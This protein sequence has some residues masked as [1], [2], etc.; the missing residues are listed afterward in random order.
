MRISTFLIIVCTVLFFGAAFKANAQAPDFT[1]TNLRHTCGPGTPATGGFVVHVTNADASQDSLTVFV[2][3]GASVV[4]Q[5]TIKPI[6]S[7]PFD[8]T[9][10]GLTGA[11]AG[12]GRSYLVLVADEN[13]SSVATNGPNFTIFNFQA[14]V[15]TVTNN[16]NADCTSPSGAIT[17]NLAGNTSAAAQPIV[18][19]WAGPVG[20]VDPGTK[21][22][23]GLRGGDYTLTYKDSNTPATSC[24]LGP[25]HI[26]DPSSVDFTITGP[27][28][29]CVGDSESVTV[30]ATTSGYTYDVMEGATVLGSGAGTGSAIFITVPSA[31]LPAG[32]HT[33]TVRATQGACNPKFNNAPNLTVTVN[34]APTYSNG[35]P[36]NVCSS[37]ASGVNL[38]SFKTGALDATSFNITNIATTLTATAGS[39]ATGTGFAANVIADDVWKNTTNAPVN[40]VYTIVPLAGICPG[41]SFTVT[42]AINPQ[43][44]FNSITTPAVCSSSAIGVT[45]DPQKKATSVNATS[46]NVL[47]INPHGMT[48]VGGSPGT[49]GATNTTLADDKWLNVTN[50]IVNVDYTITP[51]SASGCVGDQFII[52]VPISPQPDYNNFNNAPATVCSQDAINVDL[53]T[54]QKGTSIAATSFN[55]TG[56]TSTGLTIAGGAPATG[57]GL[58]NT[59]IADDQWKNVT[60]ANVN[61]VYTV[62]PVIGTCAGSPFTITVA[63]KPE[64]DYNNGTPTVC[65][66]VS[67]GVNLDSFAKGTSVVAT[68][69]DITSIV[70][71]GL[72]AKAGNPVTGTGF[73][74]AEI[75]NDQW[76]NLTSSSKTATYTVVPNNG[77]CDGTP[78]TVT[79]TINAEPDV[80]NYDS[81]P[82]GVC[83]G[84][85]LGID[86]ST[87]AV[88][89]S[90]PATTYSITS[91]ASTSLTASGGSPA[92]GTGLSNS[93]IADDAW[94]NT[95]TGTLPVVYTI[96]P[97]AGTCAGDPFT[98]TV[99]IVPRPVFTN[100]S[101]G[102]AAGGICAT[103]LGIDLNS[104]QNPAGPAAT[105][106]NITSI[107]STSLVAAGGSPATGNG[108]LNTEIADDVW[109]NTTAVNHDVVYTIVPVNGS[110]AG[111]SFTVTVTIK[112]QPNY[113]T[114]GAGVCSNIALGPDLNSLKVSGSSTADSFN[115]TSIAV[116]PGLT[117]TSATPIVT[118]ITTSSLITDKW[119]NVTA[120]LLNVVYT[121]IP[122]TG[123]CAGAPFTLTISVSPEPVYSSVTLADLCSE[124]L[125]NFDLETQYGGTSVHATTFSYVA[126]P[127]AG[128]TAF[129]STTLTGS[130]NNMVIAGHQWKNVTNAALTVVYTITPQSGGFCNGVPFTITVKIN[131]Q[132]D[133]SDLPA[134]SLCSETAL[135]INLNTLQ[136]PT[137]ILATT[138]DIVSIT[139]TNLTRKAGTSSVANG[140]PNT[141]LAADAWTN[142]TA[143]TQDVTYVI[144]PVIGTCKGDPFTVKVTIKPQPDYFTASK[145][146]CSQV[147]T[148]VDL[149]ILANPAGIA[150]DSYSI[151]S[152]TSAGLTA[153]AGSPATGSGLTSTVISD[154]AWKNTTSGSLDVV[155][156]IV[157]FNG[158]CAGVPFTMTINVGPEPVGANDNVTSCTG[159]SVGYD[160]VSNV[161]T[162]GNNLVTGTTFSWLAVD[163]TNV[164]GESTTAQAGGTI[165]NNLV[166]NTTSSQLVVYTVVPTS[167]TGCVGASFTVTVTVSPKPVLVVGQT[168]QACSGTAVGYSILLNPANLPAGTTFTW[169]APVM[170]DG[171]TQGTAQSTELA[172]GPIGTIHINDVLVNT[173]SAPITATYTITPSINGF[174]QGTPQTVV[175]TVNQ[176]ALA[177]AGINQAIC[178]DNGPYTLVGSSV[179]GSAS[180]GTWSIVSQPAGGDGALS[181]T[182]P[183]ANPNIAMVTFTATV[184]GDYTLALTTDDPAGICGPVSGNVVITVTPRPVI[185]PGQSKLVCAN[186]PVAYEI[187]LTPANLPLN[188]VFNW[189]D[190]D[191][192]TGATN[193]S[194]GVNVALGT[195]GTPHINDILRNQGGTNINVTYTVTPSVGICAG[196][197]ENILI[198]V[199]PAP[200]VAFG[201]N[202][203]ICSG[204]RVDYEILLNP[205]N[206]PPGTT[207]SW[208]DP[209]GSGS[210]RSKLNVAA[211]PA[212]T[213]HI[214]DTLYNGT[215]SAIHVIYSVISRGTNGCIGITRDVDV[216]VNSGAVAEAGNAQVICSNGTATLSGSS[217]GGLATQGTWSIVSNPSGGDGVITNGTATTTPNA[218]TFKA[219]VAGSYT[220]QL[221]TDDPAGSCGPAADV[222]VITVK[223]PG[224]PSC[225]GGSG[226]CSN[227]A[228]APIPTPAT[229]ANSDGSVFFDIQPAV[230]IS[231]DVTI[232][233]DGTG[234]TV[235]PS[236]RTNINN[237]TFNV[238]AVGT[239][240]YSIIYG[241]ATCTKTGVFSIDRSG[242]VGTVTARNLVDPVCFSDGGSA[243]L[244][245]PG[246]TGNI[247]EWSDDGVNFHNFLVGNPVAGLPNG[248]IAVQRA[249]DPCA[250]GVMLNFN[251]PVQIP[252]AFTAVDATCTG[253]DGTIE[254]T[255]NTGGT[256]PYTF[257]L[258]GVQ[259]TPTADNAFH[260][261]I[262]GNYS[263]VVTDA[264]GCS[265]TY[266]AITI[267]QVTGPAP[268]DTLFIKTSISVPDLASGSALVGVKPSGLEPYETRLELTTP[269]FA[270]QQYVQDWTEV[271]LNPQDL[272]FE[273]SYTNIFAGQ[274]TLGLRDASGCTHM[275]LFT[276]DVD[277]NVFIPNIFTPNGDGS[278]EVFYIRNLPAT[279]TKLLITNRW[280]KEIYKTSSYQNDWD[281]GDT[282]DGMYYY[283]VTIAGQK[284][285]G[286]VEILR[287]Q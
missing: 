5:V 31:S 203:L 153:V 146:V 182:T 211:D 265:R 27:T 81:S 230:P 234:S 89:G 82:G 150:A 114:G 176:A 160:L 197:P 116:D 192:P 204:D 33:L 29:I 7:F 10:T 162:L 221:M 254:I 93:V 227:V 262:A 239:Y 158:T 37:V 193:A 92:T 12:G 95:T 205:A 252:V 136:K 135:G 173:S 155:Y 41:N 30:S 107:T 275:Y 180:T 190:P 165:T 253:N 127:A 44:D 86:L 133:Y 267:N 246:E 166:N 66:D 215:A 152:I 111:N 101:N 96:T 34:P 168:T 285:V 23:S 139:S 51:V 207:F 228:I 282:V 14:S 229:C 264:A 110:C 276:I 231:G 199:K 194:N 209:D 131:S 278:N 40:V 184:A 175:V 78:F 85:V 156:S 49:G 74:G 284:F 138:F 137:S 72:T 50:A 48:A 71:T 283:T 281:G 18:Y 144:R 83:S 38:A 9:I 149:S 145:P 181:D 186:D 63:I 154:D 119:Q 196:T 214:T 121:V 20:F 257:D 170:S 122:I 117:N 57:T 216:T 2:Y 109:S 108:L 13:N 142:V 84:D 59:V 68:S 134:T 157:P 224:D 97:F 46:Y 258:N 167:S 129:G 188:T 242:T 277:N 260:N 185:T 47:F 238:L 263:L 21:N 28:T 273:Q 45:I 178:N 200:D 161:A 172:A 26:T 24:T 279:D 266:S 77:T 43:P 255:N 206:T 249:G 151:T 124:D 100:Y 274:Y 118:G 112:P 191:G 55:I 245:V 171:S 148:G 70:S 102:A 39:P 115:I 54:L 272:K 187:K 174:C 94:T 99:L 67:V 217:V 132:P 90:T 8:Q 61:V 87:L 208:P 25:I 91:I 73:T 98:V 22:I 6:P 177:N 64:P 236:P 163:N 233:I 287:G 103:P 76:E 220:L 35:T 79:V 269:L 179:S 58:S 140:L 4:K 223:A 147:P 56:I 259:T 271:P 126:A 225:T 261:L 232:T 19:S 247:L 222:V 256:A 113:T 195:P 75:S 270:S 169:P 213:L 248:L 201:Q 141:I 243:I 32:S 235:L 212:G 237:F 52:T 251:M 65:S 198:T 3:F 268:L 62:V 80:N 250:A 143:T 210:G 42:I 120:G 123:T 189:A 16:A 17:V 125:V 159:S 15:G 164:T 218:A 286:W 226:T 240:S 183:L 106:F 202:K 128:L 88:S 244:D 11:P 280:G 130:G 36:P 105:T 60:N 1:V 219:S 241:D 69:Y 104:L 53:A